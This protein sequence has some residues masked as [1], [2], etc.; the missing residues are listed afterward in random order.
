[1]R[2]NIHLFIAFLM[3]LNMNLHKD[4]IHIMDLH[5]VRSSVI[6]VSTMTDNPVI[7]TDN[8][9]THT[10]KCQGYPPLLLMDDNRIIILLVSQIS[11]QDLLNHNRHQQNRLL[12]FGLHSLSSFIMWVIPLTKCQL[13]SWTMARQVIP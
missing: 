6:P 7:M 2:Y 13:P 3:F 4:N 9:P 8:P 5:S 10:K 1:M 11:S 12:I